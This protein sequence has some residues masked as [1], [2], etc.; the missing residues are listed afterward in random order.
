MIHAALEQEILAYLHK[1]AP[2]QQE[3]VLTFVQ[4]LAAAPPT[5]VP[6][7]LLLPFAGSIEIAQLEAITQAIEAGCEQVNPNE[8]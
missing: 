2:I 8:W 3:Q 5:G 1:L 6:G 4:R 7:S